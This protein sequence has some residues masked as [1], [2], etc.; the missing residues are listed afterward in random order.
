MPQRRAIMCFLVQT[1]SLARTHG[2][3]RTAS[4]APTRSL[5][6]THGPGDRPGSR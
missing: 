4:L 6:R 5:A 1:R 2:L 3:A